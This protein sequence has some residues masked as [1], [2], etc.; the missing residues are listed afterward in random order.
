ME[1]RTP[2]QVFKEYAEPRR[3]IPSR[4]KKYLFTMRYIRTVQRSGINLD[5]VFYQSK[6][7]IDHIGR[8]VEVRRP[9]DDAGIVHI[10]SIPDR[11]YLFDAEHLVRSG[12]PQEDIQKMKKIKNDMKALEKKYNRKQAEYD[13]GVFKTP[14]EAYAEEALQVVGGE[15]VY[16]NSQETSKQSPPLKLVNSAKQPARKI[17]TPFDID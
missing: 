6:D 8:K 5:G 17:K 10:F 15:P 3:E 2:M 11:V 16:V 4:I 14:A 7:F 1:D 13:K 12:V 9:I